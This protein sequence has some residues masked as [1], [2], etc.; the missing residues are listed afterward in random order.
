MLVSEDAHLTVFDPATEEEIHKIIMSS[1][2]KSCGLDPIPTF[3]LKKCIHV[4]L[5]VITKIINL[6]FAMARVPACFKLA[7]V[8]PLLKKVFLDPEVF[9][10]LRLVSTLPFLSKT[11]ERAAGKRMKVHKDTKKLNEKN[12]SAYREGHSTETALVRIQNDV[13]RAIDTKRCV[14]LVLLDMS[15]AFDTVDHSVLLNRLSNRF[16]IQGLALQWIESY[17]GDRKQFVLVHGT[18]SDLQ[19]L[20]CNVPQGSVLGPGLFGDYS[21]PVGDIYRDHDV[22]Y[23][24][25]ADDNQ[26][27]LSFSIG[28]EEVMLHR[29]ERCIHD[30]RLWMATNYLKVNDEKTEFIILGSKHN[31]AKVKTTEISVGESAVHASTSVKNIGATFDEE[32]KMEKQV[33]LTCRSAW[34]HLYKLSKIKKYLS[35][36]QLR[37]VIQAFVISK[38][39]QNNSLLVGLPKCLIARLQSV[40]NA[41]AKLVCGINRY[42]QVEPPLRDLHWLPVARRIDFKVLLLCFKCMN[43][44]GPEYLS[45]LLETYSPT[46]CLRSSNANLLKVPKTSMKTYGDRAFSVAAPKLWNSLPYN[47]RDQKTV[48]GFKT[49]LK[50]YLF[51]QSFEL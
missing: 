22:D 29:L 11:L 47:V 49:A 9:K 45:E 32:M 25:Y 20:D 38:L 50:T 2:S 51:K 16:G 27:Y 5:P 13:L 10:N 19:K 23:H 3:L 21:S 6:S 43:D 44:V 31:L 40:Q 17:L 42:E 35:D 7:A 12:Q 30:V 48:T 39:D 28:E 26:A 18:K 1:A 8:I 14:F 4:L 24:Q 41:A 37:S 36:S 46:R 33:A 15:A 34:H